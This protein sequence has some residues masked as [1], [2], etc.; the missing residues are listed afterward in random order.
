MPLLLA[1]LFACGSTPTAPPS[2]GGGRQIAAPPAPTVPEGATGG[3]SD[4]QVEAARA[5][6]DAAMKQLGGTL[7]G[8]LVE[9]MK[10][11]G[12]LAAV[13][14]CNADAQGL[15][16]QVAKD[17][18]VQVGRSSLKLR[19]PKNAPPDWVKTWLEANEGKPAAEAQPWSDVKFGMVQSL[20]PLAVEAPCL[21]CHGPAD[22]IPADVRDKLAAAYPDDAAT[23]YAV[24]D[25]RGAI[26]AQVPVLAQGR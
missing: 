18:G 13:T 21:V 4:T 7:K 14:V 9:T 8:K 1:L 24:G 23:G 10:T 25:L 15:T 16:E 11:E 19:N 3:P 20:K 2:P 26:W 22:Q 12:P 5:S 6:A 17:T